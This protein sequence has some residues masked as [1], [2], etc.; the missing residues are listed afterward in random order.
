MHILIF[1]NLAIVAIWLILELGRTMLEE[2]SQDIYTV[3]HQHA[4]YFTRARGTNKY[5]LQDLHSLLL[6]FFFSSTVVIG[7]T[8]AKGTLAVILAT[9]YLLLTAGSFCLLATAIWWRGYAVKELH[10]LEAHYE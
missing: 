7:C 4:H 9:A 3:T 10:S 2:L 5:W 8:M 1:I 6:L